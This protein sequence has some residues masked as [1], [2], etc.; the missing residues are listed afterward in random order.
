[1]TIDVLDDMQTKMLTGPMAGEQ[2][3][4]IDSWDL[5]ATKMVNGYNRVVSR[6]HR[7]GRMA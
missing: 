4:S 6:R 1:M 2:Q 3:M 5:R 7:N